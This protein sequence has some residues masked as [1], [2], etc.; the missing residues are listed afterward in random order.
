[1][2]IYLLLRIMFIHYKSIFH[3]ENTCAGPYEYQIN[4]LLINEPIINHILVPK[5]QFGKL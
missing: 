4:I 5:I 1:M 2:G 3:N